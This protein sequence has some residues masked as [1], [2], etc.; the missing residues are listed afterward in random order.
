MKN[1]TMPE[2]CIRDRLHDLVEVRRDEQHRNTRARE[3]DELFADKF[4]RAHVNAAR[5]LVGKNQHRVV[6][7]LTR[8]DDLLNIAAGEM[9]IRDRR[10]MP[11]ALTCMSSQRQR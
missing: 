5:G 9:C 7:E 4:R 3:L 2:V 11:S 1:G 8:N 6:R 10:N